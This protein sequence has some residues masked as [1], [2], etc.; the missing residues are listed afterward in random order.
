MRILFACLVALFLSSSALAEVDS[1]PIEVKGNTLNIRAGATRAEITGMLKKAFG[2]E[3]PS[4]ASAERL[5]YDYVAKPGEGPLAL[6]FDF[7]KAGVLVGL[8]IDAN[9]KQQNPV[10]V[11]LLDWL[12]QNAGAGKKQGKSTR[13]EKSGFVFKLKEVKDAGDDS[14]YGFEISKK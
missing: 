14:S 3:E 5:Q 4:V 13:W 6:M 8:S 1:F 9:M 11:K 2:A 12:K 10:A 7:N